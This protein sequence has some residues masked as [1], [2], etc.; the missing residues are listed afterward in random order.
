MLR[1]REDIIARKIG[2]DYLEQVR[3]AMKSCF[4]FDAW[5]IQVFRERIWSV[6]VQLFAGR[7]N[8]SPRTTIV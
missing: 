3:I 7:T 5:R 8:R 2:F 6:V 1:E 4:R